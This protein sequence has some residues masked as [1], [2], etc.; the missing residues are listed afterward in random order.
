M[1][2]IGWVKGRFLVSDG[3]CFYYLTSFRK[4]TVENIKEKEVRE[5]RY[6]GNSLNFL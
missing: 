3:I 2:F 6:F 1:V 5:E 4:F